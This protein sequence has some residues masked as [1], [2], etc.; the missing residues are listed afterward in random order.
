MIHA[1]SAMNISPELQGNPSNNC[2]DKVVDQHHPRKAR[3]TASL[4]DL[5]HV[6]LRRSMTYFSSCDV[7]PHQGNSF[8]FVERKNK[9]PS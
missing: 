7:F 3:D 2:S 6:E 1:L 4:F 8:D 9:S 5:Q